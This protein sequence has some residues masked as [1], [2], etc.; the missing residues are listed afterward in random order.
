MKRYD[1]QVTIPSVNVGFRG[2]FAPNRKAPFRVKIWPNKPEV[3]TVR[4]YIKGV[5]CV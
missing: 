5:S 4:K 1:I 3:Y 2:V